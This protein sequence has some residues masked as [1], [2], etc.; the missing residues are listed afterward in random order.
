MNKEDYNIIRFL[1]YLKYRANHEG[2][3]LALEEGF[4][5]ESFH[6]GVR[7]FFGV[8]IDDSGLPMH[9]AQQPYDGFLDEWLSRS[10]N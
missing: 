8:T 2:V 9:D 4:I 6:V 1:D 7:F 10:I 5:L 3:P